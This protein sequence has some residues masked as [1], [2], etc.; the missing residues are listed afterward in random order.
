[1]RKAMGKILI[2]NGY[3]SSSSSSSSSP[4]TEDNKPL[5]LLLSIQRAGPRR[6]YATVS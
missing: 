5:I 3:I 1:M 4:V 6:R 2:Q